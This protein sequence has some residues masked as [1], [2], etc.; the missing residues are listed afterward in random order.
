M[1]TP[2]HGIA[3]VA[4]TLATAAGAQNLSE[5]SI[6]S[7]DVAP[8]PAYGKQ[9]DVAMATG[10]DVTLVAWSDD[11]AGTNDVFGMR[12]DAGGAFLDPAPFPIAAGI[13]SQAEPQVAWNGSNFLVAWVSQE[14]TTWYYEDRIATARVSTAG[15]VLDATPLVLPDESGTFE[16]AS[17]GT[18]FLIVKQGPGPAS[19]IDM[20][21]FRISD[22]GVLL[23]PAGVLFTEGSYFM[24]YNFDVAYAG[25]TW[26]FAWEQF[27]GSTNWDILG[28]RFDA[29]LQ[30]L[31]AAPAPLVK[32]SLT[33]VEPALAASDNEFLLVYWHQDTYWSQG[34]LG[35]RFDTAGQPI[36]GSIGVSGSGKSSYQPWPD[37]VWDGVQWIVAWA[38]IPETR[39]ARVSTS[40]L[41]SDPGGVVLSAGTENQYSPAIA[42]M[43][44][45]PG[46]PASGARVAWTDIRYPTNDVFGGGLS[47]TGLALAEVPI[48][49]GAGSHSRSKVV[50]NGSGTLTV[51]RS[52]TSS[53]A[54][55]LAWRTDSLGH[56]LDTEPIEV[57]SGEPTVGAPSAAWN[58]SLYLV[59][60]VDW[61][62]GAYQVLGRRMHPDGA[63]ADPAPYP[64]LPGHSADV[65]A[66]GETFLVVAAHYPT[67]PEYR[68]TYGARVQG[69]DGAVL[70]SPAILLSGS[71]SVFPRVTA[72]SDRFLVVTERHWTHDESSSDILVRPFFPDGSL[73][74][75]SSLASFATSVQF[76]WGGS[77]DVASDGTNAL[78]AW[79]SGSNLLNT[80]VFVRPVDADAV[81]TGPAIELTDG[82]FSGQF[83]PT[84]AW[85]GTEFL[86]AYESFEDNPLFFDERPDVYGMRLASDGSTLDP[87]GFAIHPATYA[88]RRPEAA[89]L[90][91][92]RALVSAAVFEDDGFATFRGELVAL[93][94]E[95][96]S[97][98][99]VGTPGCD[100]PHYLDASGEPSVGNP[101][102]ELFCSEA[103]ASTV[104]LGLLGS[105]QDL[106]GTDYGYGF[107][108]HV[109]FGPGVFFS[110][111]FLSDT[112][113]FSTSDTFAIPA[114]P[115]L[116]GTELY[117]QAAFPWTGP[118][119]PSALGLSTS[120]GLKLVIQP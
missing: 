51:A 107:L 76:T 42:T 22:Q 87:A 85:T 62:S 25:G 38:G 106:A 24:I 120:D 70:D 108:M 81:A 97:S 83:R 55:I 1:Y 92:G 49:I 9:S 64:I 114:V 119:S 8:G 89:G 33:E 101:A 105:V 2:I 73:G 5:P 79:V 66:V 110:Y 34:I 113:G 115:S 112:D 68:F 95:G 90:G 117:A 13:G 39:A 77:I 59:A 75:E 104:G 32:T 45:G 17:D 57:F 29:N 30:S 86:V 37:A 16:L 18:S 48:S 10:G 46:G 14:A 74:V 20:M 26:L 80:D 7:G 58:G 23:D 15:L 27:S 41:V 44:G 99:G 103:P 71:Y 40:G 54:R 28:R 47:G 12:L 84:L 50:P 91:G 19:S 102:F 94:P 100:G 88:A 56:A 72:A 96:V 69:S 93:R 98:Y 52:Q 6:L 4:L 111:T 61:S 109:G 67:N 63:F 36:G 11:R 35:Q 116:A 82:V 21:A 3:F 53:G 60:W 31:D 65:A 78:V 118:C 43:P